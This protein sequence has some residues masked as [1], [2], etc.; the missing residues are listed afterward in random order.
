MTNTISRIL[1]RRRWSEKKGCR[2]DERQNEDLRMHWIAE[3]LDVVAEQLV[4]VDGSLFNE[5]TDWRLRSWAL[6][7]HEGRYHALI[8]ERGSPPIHEKG[9]HP[10]IYHSYH[11]KSSTV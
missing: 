2:I 6:I 3:L 4:H 9:P 10:S 5:T 7:D 8:H 1:K 11:E